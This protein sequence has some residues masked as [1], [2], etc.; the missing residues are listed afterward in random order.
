MRQIC[1]GFLLGLFFYSEDGGD[2][3][4]LNFT[5]LPPDYEALLFQLLSKR[6]LNKQHSNLPLQ[7][8]RNKFSYVCFIPY[9]KQVDTQQKNVGILTS[10]MNLTCRTSELITQHVGH[11]I[12][13]NPST[14]IKIIRLNAC[15]QCF[16]FRT[17]NC[18]ISS[19][20][21]PAL[22]ADEYGKG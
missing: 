5:S 15:K 2:M 16:P 6:V 18:E 14:H 4:L 17:A 1:V 13:N 12:N 10:G 3:F 11:I 19:T 7:L 8:H 21:H 22:K 20:A 9:T